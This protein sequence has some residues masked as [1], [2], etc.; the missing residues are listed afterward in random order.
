MRKLKEFFSRLSE[1]FWFAPTLIILFS[2]ALAIGLVELDS[3]VDRAQL[4]QYW[5][6]FGVGADGS[7]QMLSAIAG[8][9]I[10]VAGVVFSITI[11]ALSMAS[12]QYSPRVLHNFMRDKAN[13]I[14]L[15][16]FVGIFVYCL[17]VLR[18]IT[19]GD[20]E[21]IPSLSVF[22]AGLLALVGVGFLVFFIH[23]IAESVQASNII[24]VVLQETRKTIDHL[25]PQEMGSSDDE[26]GLPPSATE[27]EEWTPIAAESR[28]YI[29]SV[30][31]D[32][33]LGIARERG[34]VIRMEYG[35]GEYVVE[36]TPLISISASTYRL[37]IAKEIHQTFAFSNHRNITQ[38]PAF[39]IQQ[40]VDIA[41]RAL[42]P[43][44]N[45]PTTAVACIERLTDALSFLAA[46]HIPSRY[47][48]DD[49][50]R[51]RVIAIRPDFESL[52]NLAFGQLRRCAAGNVTIIRQM[53]RAVRIISS[54]TRTAGRRRVLLEQLALIEETSVCE[55]QSE[56]D[57]GFVRGELDRVKWLLKDPGRY[58][59]EAGNSS[60]VE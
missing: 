12:S 51:L 8:S 33:M 56:R 14:V 43:G 2:A 29:Q 50:R 32:A 26:L 31:A 20:S 53:L 21:F 9:M 59:L 4:S 11:V 18:T 57:L 15:G 6:L 1:S 39:G 28:G 49:E 52:V 19:E 27:P 16:V 7:R 46:R 3:R 44:V 37:E 35:I 47:R 55:I 13:Q 38:D 17:I 24:S 48:L 54:Q 58:H 42:S 41:L 60:L 30:D 45:D 36:R 40:L 34:I 22:V 10:T 25:F 23:H 5:Q